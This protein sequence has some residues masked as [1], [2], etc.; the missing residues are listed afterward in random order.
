MVRMMRREAHRMFLGRVD[1]SMQLTIPM[2]YIRIIIL[3]THSA[4]PLEAV[5]L[6]Y[7][8]ASD[9]ALPPA[10]ESDEST[11]ELDMGTISEMS[12]PRR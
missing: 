10:R 12:L 5:V 1:H 6:Q 11:Q 8:V 7:R 4:G 2:T 9:D 3:A